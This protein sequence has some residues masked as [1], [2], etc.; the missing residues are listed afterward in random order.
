[1]WYEILKIVV[2]VFGPVILFTV[3][4][5]TLEIP[6][7]VAALPMAAHRALE[8]AGVLFLAGA[9]LLPQAMPFNSAM[10]ILGLVLLAT[11]FTARKLSQFN[12]N[13]I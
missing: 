9:L 2:I 1:M 4:R 13:A 11:P 5:A 10:V 12:T 3:S 6:E 8:L 7:Q